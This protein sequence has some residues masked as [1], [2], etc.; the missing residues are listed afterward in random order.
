MMHYISLLSAFGCTIL[1]VLSRLLTNRHVASRSVEIAAG[2]SA[3]GHIPP[4]LSVVYLIG[5]VG[6]II[7]FFWSFFSVGWWGLLPVGGLYLLTGLVSS[8]L[9]RA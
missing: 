6:L 2:G 8:L 7:T 9:S 5:I 3:V 4:W 1:I